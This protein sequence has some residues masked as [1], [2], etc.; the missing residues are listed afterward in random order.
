[1]TVFTT[2]SAWWY[3]PNTDKSVG[4]TGASVCEDCMTGAGVASV[5]AGAGC[6]VSEVTAFAAGVA[7]AAIALPLKPATNINDINTEVVFFILLRA[8]FTRRLQPE[9][10]YMG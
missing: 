5:A 8:V 1:M 9:S 6:V 7:G 3:M 4:M 10:V 2:T